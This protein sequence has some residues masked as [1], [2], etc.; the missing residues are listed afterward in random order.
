MK[1]IFMMVM[2]LFLTGC[3]SIETVD[4]SAHIKTS[5]V[6][7]ALKNHQID[8]TLAEYKGIGIFISK[9]N[10]EKPDVYEFNQNWLVIYEFDTPEER[11]KGGTEFAN[12]MLSTDAPSYKSFVRRNIFLIYVHGEDA[13][14]SLET[15]IQE[16][17]DSLIEG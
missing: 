2:L 8:A 3:T 14:V 4:T 5:E 1:Q 12:K 17:L 11:E 16:A 10:G 6:V 9:L 7:E 15:Q 13:Q